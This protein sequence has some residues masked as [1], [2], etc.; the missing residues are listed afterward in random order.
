MNKFDD[1]LGQK[2]SNCES[3]RKAL[4]HDLEIYIIEFDLPK[5]GF[6]KILSGKEKIRLC[7]QCYAETKS[8]IDQKVYRA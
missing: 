2:K 6:N 1:N 8:M 4:Y 5:E 3:C 7:R